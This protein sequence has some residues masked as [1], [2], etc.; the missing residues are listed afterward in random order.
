M[1][2]PFGT[3]SRLMQYCCRQMKALFTQAV[4][5]AVRLEDTAQFETLVLVHI[6]THI[7]GVLCTLIG[8]HSRPCI[9][10]K[11]PQ[12]AAIHWKLQTF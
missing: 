6:H 11:L 12:L 1:E 9:V 2:D 5:G 3:L 10:V 4:V 8:G 7:C